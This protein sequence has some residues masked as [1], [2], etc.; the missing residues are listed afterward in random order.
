[1]RIARNLALLGTMMVGWLYTNTSTVSA[2]TCG[3]CECTYRCETYNCGGL[4]CCRCL[5]KVVPAD[6]AAQ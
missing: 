3:S 4:I 1:M 5:D 2:D 6:E